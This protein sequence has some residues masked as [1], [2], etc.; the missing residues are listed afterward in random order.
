MHFRVMWMIRPR[1]RCCQPVN[2]CKY[3]RKCFKSCTIALP[4]FARILC[5]IMKRLIFRK[6]M[7]SCPGWNMP[8]WIS[9]SYQTCYTYSNVIWSRLSN[10]NPTGCKTTSLGTW[11]ISIGSRSGCTAHWPVCAYH[12]SRT[13]WIPC[14]Q[15][16]KHAFVCEISSSLTKHLTMWLHSV[17][18]SASYRETLISRT[19]VEGRSNRFRIVFVFFQ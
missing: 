3:N 1:G 18:S 19:C 8:K 17:W 11:K 16:P 12:A 10:I 6:T 5:Q 15:L 9:L 2:G 14:A 4:W 7:Q 13:F